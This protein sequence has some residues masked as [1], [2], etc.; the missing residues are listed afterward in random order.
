M[1]SPSTSLIDSVK[2][3]GYVYPSAFNLVRNVLILFPILSFLSYLQTTYFPSINRY[4]GF[5][6]KILFCLHYKMKTNVHFSL[7][8]IYDLIMPQFLVLSV[9]LPLQA[10]FEA[11]QSRTHLV[12]CGYQE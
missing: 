3:N 2:D 11:A 12:S 7:S 9:F 10:Y 4:I 6:S 1:I 5:R 8:V